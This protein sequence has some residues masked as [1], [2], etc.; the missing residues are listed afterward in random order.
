MTHYR[1]LSRVLSLQF[2]TAQ[3]ISISRSSLHLH[4]IR[5]SSYYQDFTFPPRH[6]V[7]ASTVDTMAKAK[8]K[9]VSSSAQVP[10]LQTEPLHLHTFAEDFP[11]PPKRRASKRIQSAEQ[12]SAVFMNPDQNADILDG[13]EALRASPDA[14]EKDEMLDFDKLGI[15]ASKQIKEEDDDKVPSL[16]TGSSDS[17]LSEVSDVES[18]VK[19]T[20]TKAF[21]QAVKMELESDSA[22]QTARKV[23]PSKMKKEI[24]KEPQYLD[25]DADGEEEADEEEIQAA[26][27][28]PPPVNS[29]YLPLP[30]KGR[31]GYVSFQILD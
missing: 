12:T 8:R 6:Q 3:K 23:G 31:I 30:W 22:K 16:V 9:G 10:L 29:D 4:F 5:R 20:A 13:A 25:P 7:R 27:S 28:R 15:D 11:P 18:P 21:S 26:L 14:E 17:S 24:S 19:R 1:I 2:V